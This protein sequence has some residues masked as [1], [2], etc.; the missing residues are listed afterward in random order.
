MKREETA[1]RGKA[2]GLRNRVGADGGSAGQLLVV[3][4]RGRRCS[5]A[6][7]PP[8]K[9]AD[10]NKPRTGTSLAGRKERG[11]DKGLAIKGGRAKPGDSKPPGALLSERATWARMQGMR[12]GG[13]R[14]ATDT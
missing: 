6:E 12:Q 7:S 10:A 13:R 8:F 1:S 14:G 9:A 5:S 3:V 2:L 4:E 11:P